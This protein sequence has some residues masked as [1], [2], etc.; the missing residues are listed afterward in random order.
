MIIDLCCGLG[1]FSQAFVNAGYEV[2]KID[3]N[4]EFKPTIQADICNLPL[5]PELNPDLLLMSPP[6]Q[7]FSLACVQ[8][9]KKGVRKALEMVGSCLEAVVSLKPKRWLMENPKARLRWFIGNGKQTIRY[10]DYDLITKQE[11]LTDF[12]GNLCLP[13]VKG[14]RRF[15]K[16]F[17]ADPIDRLHRWRD[18]RPRKR[19]LRSLIPIGVSEAILEGFENYKRG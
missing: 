15:R 5:R 10:S 12:W 9:P 7:R 13:M 16:E 11:K 6:C 2:I 3:I 14:E 17:L 4:K 19:S 8:W 1:G 18:E